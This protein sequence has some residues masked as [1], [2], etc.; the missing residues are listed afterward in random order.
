MVEKKSGTINELI[1]DH[2]VYNNGVNRIYPNI[3][4][5]KLIIKKLNL[6]ESTCNYIR[7]NPFYINTKLNC[8][9]EFDEYM[10]YME[11][12]KNFTKED[13]EIHWTQ[14][15]DHI[16][17]V[18]HEIKQYKDMNENEKRQARTLYPVCRYG[19]FQKF[20]EYLNRYENY[21]YELIPFLFKKVIE[22]LDLN[23][24][25]MAFGYFCFEIHSD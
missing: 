25:D 1:Y 7:I 3:N 20:H 11:C 15:M 2:T 9:I 24:E 4:E 22:E 5:I 16:Y 12:R 10:F 14:C 13:L 18:P 17:D 21:L 23:Q 8:Q 19:D 6:L